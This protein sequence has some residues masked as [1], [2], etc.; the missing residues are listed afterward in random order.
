[1]NFKIQSLEDIEDQIDFLGLHLDQLVSSEEKV[2]A[3]EMYRTIN[4]GLTHPIELCQYCYLYKQGK[5]TNSTTKAQ[6]QRELVQLSE[7]NITARFENNNINNPNVET[8]KIMSAVFEVSFQCLQRNEMFIKAEIFSK[9]KE[10]I[11][12]NTKEKFDIDKVLSC[13]LNIL[14]TETGEV[15]CDFLHKT[16]QEFLAAKY[17]VAKMREHFE[18]SHKSKRKQ[19]SLLKRMRVLFS[20]RPQDGAESEDKLSAIIGEDLDYKR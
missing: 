17:L 7:E 1:V 6:I 14:K 20:R 3:I 16:Y 8:G 18:S 9:L 2:N 15:Y 12:R 5:I 13:L 10:N 4:I 11:Y 19:V